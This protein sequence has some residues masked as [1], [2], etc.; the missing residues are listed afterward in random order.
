MQKNKLFLTTLFA[1]LYI[2]YILGVLPRRSFFSLKEKKNS[3]SKNVVVKCS[4]GSR[5]TVLRNLLNKHYNPEIS[6]PR[7][8]K[9]FRKCH[10][11]KKNI[12]LRPLLARR[13]P[14]KCPTIWGC[15]Y[16]GCR[17]A[18]FSQIV[19]CRPLTLGR[20]WSCLPG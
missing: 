2:G 18:V 19:R 16:Q 5:E 13:F 12:F 8:T 10:H 20:S 4:L 15:L 17:I 11:G 6:R 1:I 9:L 7:E 14:E 3:H